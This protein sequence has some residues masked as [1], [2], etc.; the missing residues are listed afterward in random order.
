MKLSISQLKYLKSLHTRKY[1]QKYHNF[2]VEGVK[3]CEEVL[4]QGDLEIELIA[5]T[6]EWA[7]ANPALLKL[8]GEQIIFVS[9]KEL[10]RISLMTTP[11]HVFMVVR[12]PKWQLPRRINDVTLYLDD[13][14]DP[15]NMGTI[16][17]IADWFGIKWVFCSPKTVEVFNPKVVQASMG[18]FLR[19]KTMEVDF[20][21]LKKTFSGIPTYGAV[22]NGKNVFETCLPSV[23][24]LVIGNE[25]R[26]ISVSIQQEL[27]HSIAIPSHSSAGAE[28]LNAGVATGILC[29]A[30]RNSVPSGV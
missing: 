21:D 17:R 28:S 8:Y 22:L 26:G 7:D 5:A 23:A 18:A 15:G 24:I 9:Q 4:R 13:L 20:G 10:S 19:V 11:N 12:Q 30:F 3:I 14:Q 2:V 1:R 27:D 16:L 29:A 6:A 25:S